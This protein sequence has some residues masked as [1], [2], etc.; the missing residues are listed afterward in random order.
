MG[1]PL[2]FKGL[3]KGAL[4]FGSSYMK[5]FPTSN[6]YADNFH[7]MPASWGILQGPLKPEILANSR[8]YDLPCSPDGGGLRDPLPGMDA[9]VQ[10]HS[11]PAPISSSAEL[12]EGQEA[13]LTIS[14]PH[15]C[16]ARPYSFHPFKVIQRPNVP[17]G[18]FI[19]GLLYDQKLNWLASSTLQSW[20]A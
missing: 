11:R 19:I 5:I 14:S 8:R 15:H 7:L 10:P 16:P 13:K 2:W 18:T 12:W 4:V 17:E 3:S 1:S 9:R 20:A 6:V